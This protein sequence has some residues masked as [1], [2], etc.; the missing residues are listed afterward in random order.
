MTEVEI[1]AAVSARARQLK[2]AVE[3]VWATTPGRNGDVVTAFAREHV[4]HGAVLEVRVWARVEGEREIQTA[5]LKAAN[6]L[7]AADVGGQWPTAK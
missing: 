4:Q 7:A 1:A 6:M 3:I 2:R 5:A